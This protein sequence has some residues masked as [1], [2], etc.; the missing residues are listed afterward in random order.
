MFNLSTLKRKTFWGGL[1]G[2]ATG[3]GLILAG[4]VPTGIQTIVTSALAIF[5]R[6][7]IET[8]AKAQ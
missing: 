2:I 4:D 1:A 8:V 7:G 6:D 3:V 5:V